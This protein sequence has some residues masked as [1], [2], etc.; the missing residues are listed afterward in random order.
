MLANALFSLEGQVAVVTGGSGV[1]GSL[2][3]RGLAHAGASTPTPRGKRV[4]DHTPAGRFGQPEDL[5]GTL[6][7]L[8]S[9]GAAFVSGVVVPVDGGFNAFSG[10]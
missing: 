10:V 8:C 3:A 1:L 5:V 6:I 7:W 4:L 9:P 2:M